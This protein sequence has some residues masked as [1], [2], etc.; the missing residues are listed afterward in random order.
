MKEY[1]RM[2]NKKRPNQKLKCALWDWRMQSM[3]EGCALIS[4]VGKQQKVMDS[5]YKDKAQGS[6]SGT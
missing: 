6:N 3:E 4:L 1:R 2:S 5:R